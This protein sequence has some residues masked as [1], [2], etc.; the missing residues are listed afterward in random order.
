[1]PKRTQ[2]PKG[3]S[4]VGLTQQPNMSPNPLKR[5][6]FTSS[7]ALA[8]VCRCARLKYGGVRAADILTGPG[9][10]AHKKNR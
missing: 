1:M 7:A 6:D 5:N 8:W 4:V 3:A 2:Y 10:A 9:A